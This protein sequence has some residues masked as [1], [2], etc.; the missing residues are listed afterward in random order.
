MYL[1]VSTDDKG[2]DLETQRMPLREY[3]AAQGWADVAEYADEAS[4]ADMR[5]RVQWRR[6]LD[7][8]ARRKIDL[9]LVWRIDRAFRSVLDAAQT[10]ER[11][12]GWGVGLRSYQEPWLDTTS[13]FGEALYYITVAYA[14]LE[15]GILRERV[16]A[17][18][19]RAR[20]QG[21]HVGRPPVTERPGFAARWAAV[22]ADLMA[23]RISISD[24]ARRARVSRATVRRLLSPGVSTPPPPEEGVLDACGQ[25]QSGLRR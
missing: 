7:D 9:V 17:G 1:R 21:R 2:Q 13:P 10:L 22:R 15:R 24:A 6:L 8:A 4:A 16:K 3:C 20:R 19:D 14:Q 11:L 18:M 12:R 5:G 25:P 23:G